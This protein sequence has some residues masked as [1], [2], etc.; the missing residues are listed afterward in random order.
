MERIT[1]QPVTTSTVNAT[2]QR[3]QSVP[4]PDRAFAA[5]LQKSQQGSMSKNLFIGILVVIVL[6][7]IGTGY[8]AARMTSKTTVATN[9]T[10]TTADTSTI[11]NSIKVG[12]VVGATDATAFK[13]SAEGVLV[14]GGIGGE[15]SHHLVRAGGDSQSVYLTSSV[16]DLKLY[17]GAKV[18]VSGETFQGQ[19]A[20]WLMDVGRLEIEQLN[21][22]LPDGAK[23]T[24][25][26]TQQSD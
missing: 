1:P 8:A 12:Q 9:Q 16:M 6:A 10:G 13:D 4:N 25:T 23:T 3:I 2:G 21:A 19:K 22:P 18:K 7:G 14:S 5:T 17:E 20:G 26:T 24:T 15:G 11:E